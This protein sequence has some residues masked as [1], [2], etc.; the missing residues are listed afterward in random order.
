[1]TTNTTSFATAVRRRLPTLDELTSISGEYY[2]CP[3]G[4]EVFK[5]VVLPRNV[6]HPANRKIPKIVHI[7]AKSRCVTKSIKKH[8]LRWKFPDHSLYLHDDNAV[9]KL[10]NYAA[11]DR[12]GN[13]LVQN[14]SLAATCMTTGATLSDIWRYVLLYYYG[15]G[16]HCAIGVG[17]SVFV[18]D[19]SIRY[20]P[21]TY[22]FPILIICFL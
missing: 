11:N 7:T 15:G 16:S 8:I 3:D 4:Y 10:L 18:L 6:T 9:Y 13:E 22:V 17:N 19:Y 1:M 2:K 20:R 5:D 21:C 14:F 12:Y